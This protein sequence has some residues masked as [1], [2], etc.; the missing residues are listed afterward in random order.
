M[1]HRVSRARVGCVALLTEAPMASVRWGTRPEPRLAVGAVPTQKAGADCCGSWPWRRASSTVSRSRS[2]AIPRHAYIAPRATDSPSTC[3]A[4]VTS[5][6]VVR[7]LS[8]RLRT[9][10][11]TSSTSGRN[12]PT[13]KTDSGI[14][15]HC[16]GADSSNDRRGNRIQHLGAHDLVVHFQPQI[17]DALQVQSPPSSKPKK[18]A[19]AHQPIQDLV[20]DPGEE[21]ANVAEGR[22]TPPDELLICAAGEVE[23]A[24]HAKQRGIPES[25]VLGEDLEQRCIGV[26]VEEHGRVDQARKGSL[27][28]RAR[29]DLHRLRRTEDLRAGPHPAGH[30]DNDLAQWSLGGLAGLRHQVDQP[31][32][33]GPDLLVVHGGHDDVLDLAPPQV[34]HQETG[35]LHAET[36]PRDVTSRGGHVQIRGPAA[37]TG[38]LIDSAVDDEAIRPKLLHCTRHRGLAQARQLDDLVA[39]QGRPGEDHVEDRR[40]V[41]V[42]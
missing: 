3:G 23:D 27:E 20:A 30:R 12:R 37:A 36:D 5:G 32:R 19:R 6:T 13:K 29:E 11:R 42:A 16:D 17:L 14:Q 4:T 34:G 41:V 10:G 28:T 21:H 22:S 1:T 33:G 40:L 31:R 8:S 25:C 9:S 7:L 35:G 2:R 24:A 39:R 18:A 38:D 15:R 26:T